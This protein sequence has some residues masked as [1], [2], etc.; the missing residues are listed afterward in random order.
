MDDFRFQLYDDTR[1][2]FQFTQIR[3]GLLLYILFLLS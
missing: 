3:N 1:D 2:I